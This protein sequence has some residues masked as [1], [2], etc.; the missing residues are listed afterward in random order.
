M[1]EYYIRTPDHESSR[2]PFNIAKLLTLAE[3][4]QVSENT[5]YYDEDKEE[6]IP[7]ALNEELKNQVF[8]KREKLSLKIAGAETERVDDE[9]ANPEA[10]KH[11]VEEMLAA[12]EGKTEETKHLKRRSQSF[13]KAA[14]LATGGLGLSFLLSAVCLIFP[15]FALIQAFYSDETMSQVLNYPILL[16]GIVDL[17][18]ALFLFLAITE[19][20]PFLRARSMITLG[21]GLYIGWAIGDPT[22]MI[23]SVFAGLG[24][25]LATIAQT[26]SVM[27]VSLVLAI[28]GNGALAYLA[29]NGR[30]EGFFELAKW[31][32]I[33]V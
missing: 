4:G 25:F 11:D 29:I 16:V 12:A 21:F 31:N 27:I 20:F 2:G 5:L 19:L 22:I 17:F 24:V 1:P 18:L 6:W 33:A 13:N 26:F 8:P 23:L 32:L 28:L 14:S 15:H 10:K 3:A 9:L 7:F 30:F